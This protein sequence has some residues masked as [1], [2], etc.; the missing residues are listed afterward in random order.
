[1]L[2]NGHEGDIFSCKFSH[3]GQFIAST[4][5]DR[6]I[7]ECLISYWSVEYLPCDHTYYNI[8]SILNIGLHNDL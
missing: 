3:D 8:H 5:F 4:G 2:L 6:Q 1:M 7:C